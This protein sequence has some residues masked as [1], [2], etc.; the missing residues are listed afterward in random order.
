[1]KKNE[2]NLI[3]LNLFFCISIVIANVVGCKVVDFGFSIFGAR[4]VASGGALTYAITFLCTDIIGEI[5]GKAEAKKAVWR[6]MCIQIFAQALIIATM[7]LRAVDADM[8]SAYVTLLGQSWYFVIGSLTAY[9]CSQTWDVFVFHKLRNKFNAKP[10]LRWIWNNTSTMTSQIIDTAVYALVSF[11]IGMGWLWSQ[12]G[13]VDLIGLFL[14]QYG[15]KFL[16]AA[17]DTPFF[18]LFTKKTNDK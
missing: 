17:I 10:A 16:L 9:I 5:W 14:G 15:L 4:V 2:Q 7:F 11:G 3:W 8:Q 13:V 1:M 6:G 18:Y 12:G